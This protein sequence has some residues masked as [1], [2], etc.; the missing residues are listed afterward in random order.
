MLARLPVRPLPSIIHYSLCIMRYALL[1]QTLSGYSTYTQREVR[2]DV[3]CLN[4][5]G[6]R[7]PG[8][9]EVIVFSSSGPLRVHCIMISETH[10]RHAH[11][12]VSGVV[13]GVWCLD[14]WQTSITWSVVKHVLGWQISRGI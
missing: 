5:A 11:P 6:S 10:A 14:S 8:A 12:R 3:F 13:F 2:L 4:R 7:T 1:N 9:M